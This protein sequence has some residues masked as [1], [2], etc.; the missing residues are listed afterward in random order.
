MCPYFHR[1]YLYVPGIS[2]M[3]QQGYTYAP[4]VQAQPGAS[5]ASLKSAFSDFFGNIGTEIGKGA[6]DAMFGQFR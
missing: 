6:A 2:P 3:P 1:Q 5:P 4:V